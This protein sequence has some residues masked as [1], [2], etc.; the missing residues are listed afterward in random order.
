MIAEAVGPYKRDAERYRWLRDGIYADDALVRVDMI[1]DHCFAE[2]DAAIDA[3]LAA[4][5]KP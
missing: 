5:E 2:L 4:K 1:T 3:V